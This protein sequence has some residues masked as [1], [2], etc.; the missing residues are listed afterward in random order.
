MRAFLAGTL[1]VF[2]LVVA[3]CGSS[4]PGGST[5]ASGN[6][7]ASKSGQQVLTDAVKAAEA[8][9]S[10]RMAGT[11]NTGGQ[12]IGLD[13]SIVKGKGATGSMTLGGEKVDLMVVGT[14][15]YMK[16]DAAFWT[17]FGGSQGSAIAQ[18]VAGKWFKFSTDNPQ[19]AAFTSF[20]DSKSL[21]D[22]LS[23]SG[24][25]IANK[26]A[27]TYKGQSVVNIY[28]G[29]T[30]G[31]LYV[32]ATGTPYP[33]AIAKTGSGEGGAITFDNWNESVTLTAPSGAIDSS[34]L[35]G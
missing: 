10:L 3:G 32:A 17:R 34:Q 35:G 20:A 28:G 15:A 30:N 9:S 16:A 7:E 27:T 31:T 33:V 14:N 8:A 11:I 5:K 29:P 24:G 19:F 23:S 4:S 2:T 6:G 18:L 13:L 21:F 1:L 22:S 12:Q 26:G 25:A